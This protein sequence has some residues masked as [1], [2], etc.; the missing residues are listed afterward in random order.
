MHGTGFTVADA[1]AQA[2]RAMKNARVLIE[3]AGSGFDGV[4][5]TRI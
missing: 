4:M 5:K 2:D 1:A 3:E